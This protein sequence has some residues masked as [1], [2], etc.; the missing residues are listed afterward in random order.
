MSE[1]NMGDNNEQE[2]SEPAERETI[3]ERVRITG[4]VPVVRP[5]VDPVA[6]PG[7]EP[8]VKDDDRDPADA[9]LPHPEMAHWTEAP[10]GEVP[11]VLARDSGDSESPSDPWSSLPP[12]AWREEHAD[13]E[14]SEVAFEPAM[15]AQDE[16]RLGSLD[17]SPDAER[18]PWT[19]D[20]D[21]LGEES[22]DDPSTAAES[23]LDRD[24]R[25]RFDSLDLD[26][27]GDE[28]TL[29]A[30][31]VPVVRV[32]K[33]PHDD[34]EELSKRPV[35]GIDR[36]ERSGSDS[37]SNT[38]P[39]ESREDSEA[40]HDDLLGKDEDS[41]LLRSREEPELQE[42]AGRSR[43]PR[44]ATD[45]DDRRRRA[46]GRRH[47]RGVS[48]DRSAAERSR[49]LDD[50]ASDSESRPHL[51]GR[52]PPL[53][54]TSSPQ[55]SRN[56]PAAVAIGLIMFLVV[57]GAFDLGALAALVVS[58]VFVLLGSIEA[59]AA[60]RRAGY[61]PAVLLGWAGTVALMVATYDKG[62]A[63]LPLVLVLMV[64]FT[65]IW[66]LSGVEPGADPVIGAASTLFVFAWVGVFG[67]FAAL[68]L[69]PSMFPH[70]HGVAYLIGAIVVTVAYDVGALAVGSRIGSHPLAPGA[71]PGKT[72]EGFFGGA[73]VAVLAAV[74]I[75]QFIHPWTVTASVALGVVVAIVAPIGDL[76]ESL[77]KRHLGL[78]DM[79]RLLP[80]H[81]GVL[82]RIDGLLFVLPATYFLVRAFG[83]G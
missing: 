83:L 70:R 51:P 20:L 13:W 33:P 15:L 1:A 57:I 35:E 67:S 29:V 65:M 74:G 80:G 71:S 36:D 18:Q 34:D 66:Y 22:G 61:Q 25:L 3:S 53:R 63:A 54:P 82:D 55:S 56:M 52:R 76:C 58:T 30:P 49:E 79:G 6:S 32:A 59:Y 19:F 50:D 68:L 27:Y 38:A 46:R 16:E 2:E 60:F 41:G 28:D 17:D 81:G 37:R 69:S 47:G 39:V 64:A 21:E 7:S 10:T 43:D 77:V 24:D 48:N 5:D 9:S 4:A 73:V 26:G 14:A 45:R 78:K 11:A 8:G 42:S 31:P 44:D 72:W 40:L 75:V 62:L 12:P 23:V